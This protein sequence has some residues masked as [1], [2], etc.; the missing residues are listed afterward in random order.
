MIKVNFV[1]H[2]LDRVNF[3]G[4]N[5][6]V[7]DLANSLVD[8][9]IDVTIYSIGLIENICCE[10]SSKVKVV[11]LNRKK[12]STNQYV[13]LNKLFWFVEIYFR[14]FKIIKKKKHEIWLTTS[15][16]L[17]LL[18]SFFKYTF[19]DVKIIGCDHTSTIFSKGLLIDKIKYL[20]LK[21]LNY[22]VA[23]T[24]EDKLF[25]EEHGLN[26][27]LIPNFINFSLAKELENKRN[28]LIFV[29]RFSPEKQPLEALKIYHFSK[30][31]AE[32]IH[33][34]MY[35]SG[36]L[37]SEIFDYIAVN[38]LNQYVRVVVGEQRPEI[39]YK[40]SIALIMTSKI[41]GFGMVLLEAI[42]RNIPCLA[43]DCP[44]G[45]RNII[46]DGLNGNLIEFG[47]LNDFLEKLKIN[48]L[49]QLISNCM[50]NQTIT[51]YDEKYVVST[52]VELLTL[53]TSESKV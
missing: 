18:F 17:N 12:H 52:W 22:V 9:E 16:P 26:T 14:F 21:K 2:S 49:N 37:E 8:K 33:M 43:Y 27:I 34:R 15:P 53:I 39:I 46:I 48:N 3:G 5:K 10:I 40:D 50:N 25:Y 13:G 30:L 51:Q 29:G 7:T 31:W 20:L 41:E 4:V 36:S 38:N 32:G 1:V 44:Y 6:V 11:S 45:P 28:A 19:S 42:S 24:K 47:N 23:L 35:G